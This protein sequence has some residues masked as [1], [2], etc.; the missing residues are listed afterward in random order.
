[1]ID[2]ETILE[3]LKSSFTDEY[4]VTLDERF[5]FLD[6]DGIP[7]PGSP[8]FVADVVVSSSDEKLIE[9]VFIDRKPKR[10]ELELFSQMVLSSGYRPKNVFIY[11]VDSK[12]EGY[13]FLDASIERWGRNGSLNENI[14]R[15][16]V[17]ANG[18]SATFQIIDR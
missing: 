4:R 3:F 13:K 10:M 6:K 9:V 15:Y 14:F 17:A 8:S 18:V 1:M 12:G 5:V 7:I 11:C 2:K 16:V